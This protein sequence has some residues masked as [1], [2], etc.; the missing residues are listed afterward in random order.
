MNIQRFRRKVQRYRVLDKRE[1]KRAIAVK[2]AVL[3]SEM[4]TVFLN[5]S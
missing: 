4:R 2:W 5:R 1:K 3:V